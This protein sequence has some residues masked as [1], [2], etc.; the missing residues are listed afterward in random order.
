MKEKVKIATIS[1]YK[2]V[3]FVF[4]ENVNSK[5]VGQWSVA[6]TLAG[7]KIAFREFIKNKLDEMVIAGVLADYNVIINDANFQLNQNGKPVAQWAIIRKKVPISSAKKWLDRR[8]A[9]HL[10]SPD[11]ELYLERW[12]QKNGADCSEACSLVYDQLGK[13]LGLCEEEEPKLLH[14]KLE[15]CDLTDSNKSS[16]EDL[17]FQSQEEAEDYWRSFCE[18]RMVEAARSSSAYSVQMLYH[19]LEVRQSDRDFLVYKL[20]QL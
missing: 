7:S 2:L 1:I 19:V 12:L 18:Q 17:Y 20:E 6:L 15:R 9:T 4:P 8:Q 5:M 10:D 3:K 11:D 14:Y 16:Q 13:V